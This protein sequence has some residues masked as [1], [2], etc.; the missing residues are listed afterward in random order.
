MQ[1]WVWWVAVLVSGLAVASAAR[2]EVAI[3]GDV[4]RLAQQIS[5]SGD[6][7]A[8]PFAIVDKR[9][10]QLVVFH[11]DGRLAGGSAA[12]LGSARGDHSSPGVGERAQSGSLRPDDT[13]TPAGRFVSQPGR[14]HTGE[15]VIWVDL[16]AAFAIHR[17]RPGAAHASR[18]RRLASARAAD[19]RVSQGC[20]VVSVAFFER[21]VQPLLG[22]RSA[23]VYVM[24]ELG[25]EETRL[26]ALLRA[27]L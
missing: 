4:W 26:A 9:A 27:S 24:P 3:S 17:L 15:A 18:A 19:K 13:T 10:A 12:L 20:V 14:N 21:V 11:A 22:A 25:L 23:V 2:A 8:M 1:N 16:Q 5:A 7:G 6:H